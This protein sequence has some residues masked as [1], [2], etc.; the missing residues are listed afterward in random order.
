MPLKLYFKRFLKSHGI[1]KSIWVL[2]ADAICVYLSAFLAMVSRTDFTVLAKA[3]FTVKEYVFIPALILAIRLVFSIILKIYKCVIRYTSTSDI[4]RI[5][6]ANL[7]GSVVLLGLNFGLFML[8]RA[9]L[10]PMSD[11]FV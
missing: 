10:I 8:R 2:L 5:L 11:L 6:I 7:S 9:Y 3:N 4:F 1:V